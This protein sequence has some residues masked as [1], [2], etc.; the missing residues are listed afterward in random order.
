MSDSRTSDQSVSHKS[1]W[2]VRG[3][4]WAVGW[5]FG[6]PIVVGA[7]LAFT[8]NS[9]PWHSSFTFVMCL[10]VAA[11]AWVV[12]C[13]YYGLRCVD[14]A[15]GTARLLQLRADVDQLASN[16]RHEK[17]AHKGRL[18]HECRGWEE[19]SRKRAELRALEEARL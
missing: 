16:I 1:E 12:G 2:L 15:Y 8:W 7:V 11:V 5:S 13:F 10:A 19:Y 3:F 6:V 14:R 18:N 4:L 17:A 9:N